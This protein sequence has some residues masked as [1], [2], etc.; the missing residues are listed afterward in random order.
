MSDE[1]VEDHDDNERIKKFKLDWL[2]WASAI[3][4]LG[5]RKSGKTFFMRQLVEHF[6]ADWNFIFAGSSGTYK[7]FRD[8]TN[9][10]FVFDAYTDVSIVEEKLLELIAMLENPDMPR[11]EKILVLIDDLGMEKGLMK[12]QIILDFFSRGRHWNEINGVEKGL[13]VIL[14][15]QY[16]KMIEPTVRS[17]IDTMFCFQLTNSE[18]YQTVQKSYTTL[19]P[20]QFRAIMK[21]LHAKRKHAQLVIH[22]DAGAAQRGEDVTYFKASPVAPRGYIG[23]DEIN[24]L[25]TRF[26]DKR[27]WAPPPPKPAEPKKPARKTRA[28]PEPKYKFESDE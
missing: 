26:Y 13:T 2:A 17:N 4:I 21:R 18:C 8:M 3:V 16:A 14:S 19:N 1:E 11:P 22:N 23:C 9:P 10:L 5:K 12:S 28:K 24:D 7:D 25:A 15:I 20:K 6:N 27:R